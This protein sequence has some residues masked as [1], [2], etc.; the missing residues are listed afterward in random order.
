M[1]RVA[2]SGLPL[3]TALL[4]AACGSHSGGGSESPA[5]NAVDGH[6]SNMTVERVSPDGRTLTVSTLDSVCDTVRLARVDETSS[7]VTLR[8][9]VTSVPATPPPNA[10]TAPV[11][12]SAAGRLDR[13][14]FT[15]KSPIRGRRL[16]TAAS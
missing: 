9:S 13:F 3:A 16:D 2:K 6:P 1:I 12:C 15:L 10:S 11:V 14:T 7:L 4:L 5:P 8:L